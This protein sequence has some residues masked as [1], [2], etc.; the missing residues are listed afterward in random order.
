VY[1]R[2]HRSRRHVVAT[3]DSGI[4]DL[5][6]RVQRAWILGMRQK[7]PTSTDRQRMIANASKMRLISD[8]DYRSVQSDL[9][10]AVTS[11]I[12]SLVIR[13]SIAYTRV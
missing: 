8:V 7:M 11:F 9:L 10:H 6:I 3:E 12:M 2:I 13:N 1:L 4:D 5:E